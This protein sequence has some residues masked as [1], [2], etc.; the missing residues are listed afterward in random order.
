MWFR[1]V[2]SRLSQAWRTRLFDAFCGSLEIPDHIVGLGRQQARLSDLASAQRRE[3]LTNPSVPEAIRA[4]VSY[5]SRWSKCGAKRAPTV[6]FSRAGSPT[7]GF[8]LRGPAAK[9]VRRDAAAD[10]SGTRGMNR[11][12]LSDNSAL[13]VEPFRPDRT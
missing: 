7:C 4:D 3:A 11:S 2:V 8:R 12:G 9:H 5:S 1:G 10:R 13:A 6:L